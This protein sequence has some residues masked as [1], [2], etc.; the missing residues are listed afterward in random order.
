MNENITT[1]EYKQLLEQHDWTYEYSDD[2]QVYLK[3]VESLTNL[4]KIAGYNERFK[5]MFTNYQLKNLRI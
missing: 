4:V 1:E 3:G 5:N 2:H